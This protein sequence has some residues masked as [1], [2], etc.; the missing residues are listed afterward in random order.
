[1][2]VGLKQPH[3]DGERCVTPARAAAKETKFAPDEGVEQPEFSN[4]ER[5]ESTPILR[6]PE[7]DQLSEYDDDSS[8]ND[9]NEFPV[10]DGGCDMQNEELSFPFNLN[11]YLLDNENNKALVWM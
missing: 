11:T 6:D 3:G 9:S 5:R 10:E 7:D 2:Y 8:D 4:D 1:M